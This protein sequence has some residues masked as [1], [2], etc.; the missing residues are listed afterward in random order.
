MTT[1]EKRNDL[2]QAIR[3]QLTGLTSLLIRA[4]ELGLEVHITDTEG[5]FFPRKGK[6]HYKARITGTQ[7]IEY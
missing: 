4:A 2:A 5:S 7:T 1:E 3:M 6:V